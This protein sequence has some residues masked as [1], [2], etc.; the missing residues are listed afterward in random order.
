MRPWFG[1]VPQ[2]G[3]SG[4]ILDKD[5]PQGRVLAQEQ[6]DGLPD[7]IIAM[8]GIGTVVAIPAGLFLLKV[9]ITAD[10]VSA[11]PTHLGR[12]QKR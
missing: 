3:R 5:L 4:K 2:G 11:G 1:L 9:Y 10:Y 8:L 12:D 7:R 6:T